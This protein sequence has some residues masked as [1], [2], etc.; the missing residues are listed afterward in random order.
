MSRALATR[1]GA[2]PRT[3]TARHP[4]G[5]VV[6]TRIEGKSTHAIFH[7]SVDVSGSMASR[8]AEG[9]SRTD[10]AVRGVK[11]VYDGVMQAQDHFGLATF[12]DTVKRLH[13]C[14]V[15]S[16]VNW[17]TDERHIRANGGGCTALY[18]AIRV[19]LDELKGSQ[20]FQ[21]GLATAGRDPP[22]KLVPIQIVITDGGNNTGSTT[23][24]Q[25]EEM[26]A[27][28]DK[29]SG[30]R[31]YLIA[32]DVDGRTAAHMERIC[33][34]AHA[35]LLR[36]GDIREMRRHLATLTEEIRVLLSVRTRSGACVDLN[37]RGNMREVDSMMKSLNVGGMVAALPAPGSTRPRRAI[38]N[39]GSGASGSGG[40]R[41]GGGSARGGGGGGATFSFS[42]SAGGRAHDAGGRPR[43]E[44]CSRG[45][46]CSFL[47]QGCCRYYHPRP[48]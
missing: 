47:R 27:R 24:E 5:A 46:G 30:F 41:G 14:M 21:R 9:V 25:V 26:V 45:P 40:A 12:D 7:V 17:A 20:R 31:F 13:Q 37:M 43:R 33:R 48:R 4:N 32:V 28:H 15:K 3:I 2:Q 19:G 38:T 29:W 44:P 23:L 18:D 35:T 42:Q 22:P 10:E 1:S 34:P 11:A 8:D 6:T 16:K 39:G 36:A